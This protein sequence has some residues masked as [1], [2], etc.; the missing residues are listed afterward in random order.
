MSIAFLFLLTIILLYLMYKQKVG[1]F[2]CFSLLFFNIASSLFYVISSELF[3]LNAGI[4]TAFYVILLMWQYKYYNWHHVFDFL[5]NPVILSVLA[6][7]VIMFL[8]NSISPYYHIYKAIID[9]AQYSFLSHVIFPIIIFP[10]IL[11]D[12]YSREE[13]VSSILFWGGIYIIVL[14]S[15]FTISSSIISDRGVLAEST[16]GLIGNIGLSRIYA[17]VV[18][19][20]FMQLIASGYKKRIEYT[21]LVVGCVLF[22]LLI[23]IIG[24]RGTLIGLCIALLAL[25]LRKEWRQQTFVV[26]GIGFVVI[27][28]S[29]TFIDFGQFQIFQRFSQFQDIESFERYHDYGKTWDIFTENGF[30]GGLGSKGYSFRTGRPWPHNII[31]EHISDY[32]LAGLVCIS[33]LL[34]FCCKY[35]IALIRHS[36]NTADLT[37][38]CAWIALCFS[39]MVSSSILGHYHFYICSG[40]LVLVYQDYQRRLLNGT[41]E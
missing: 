25:F 36:D 35:S 3:S 16:D 33:V 2:A 31:L 27:L 38:A 6:I 19:A 22:C 5:K 17:I 28:I 13:M 9:Q 41:S 11:P 8:F 29:I 20:V 7:T 40:L 23:L 37:V 4:H 32:G 39:A 1:F 15:S 18:I 34:Y 30:L 14:L 12:R 24:Q 21:S 26:A 10:L